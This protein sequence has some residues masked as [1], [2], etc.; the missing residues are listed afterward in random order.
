[1]IKFGVRSY[2]YDPNKYVTKDR[3]VAYTEDNKEI[4]F[5]TDMSSHVNETVMVFYFDELGRL[6]RKCMA[7]LIS[8]GKKR[9]SATDLDTWELEIATYPESVINYVNIFDRK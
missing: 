9:D 5:D 2:V 6:T 7:K 4:S 8:I 1:M 3:I